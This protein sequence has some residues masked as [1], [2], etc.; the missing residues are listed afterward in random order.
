MVLLLYDKWT[1]A[2]RAPEKPQELKLA[3]DNDDR[4]SPP[5]TPDNPRGADYNTVVPGD[6]SWFSL[7]RHAHLARD[8]TGGT[9]GHFSKMSHY[10]RAPS[11]DTA[12]GRFY[13][14]LSIPDS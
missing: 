14:S 1:S 11:I 6:A 7:K 9:P 10:R 8:F 3:N 4:G 13:I 5:V 2:A 12:T